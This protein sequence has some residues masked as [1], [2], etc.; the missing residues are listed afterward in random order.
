M[1]NEN[2]T[3]PI[4][5]LPSS[6]RMRVVLEGT[7]C[8]VRIVPHNSDALKAM[9]KASN[10]EAIDIFCTMLGIPHA[11]Q[12]RGAHN[13]MAEVDAQVMAAAMPAAMLGILMQGEPTPKP[14]K[15]IEQC[16]EC[17]C[18]DGN[19]WAYCPNHSEGQ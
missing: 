19:H 3:N 6:V 2:Q 10:P 14:K 4:T 16:A 18:D 12:F 13:F 15:V 8:T 7:P 5:L 17:G 11:P 1:E 9:L